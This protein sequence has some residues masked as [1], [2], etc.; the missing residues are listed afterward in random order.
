MSGK[1][2]HGSL[3]VFSPRNP[4]TATAAIVINREI[5]RNPRNISSVLVHDRDVFAAAALE[6]VARFQFG[7]SWIARFNHQEKPIIGGA[8]ES[9]P[10]KNRMMWSRQAVHDEDGEKRS[11]SREEHGELEHDREKRRHRFPVP[12][13][14]VD[15]Q[16]VK[17]PRGT[18]FDEHGSEQPGN[19]AA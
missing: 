18:E 14:A 3:V 5:K 15:N 11:E 13:F 10:V 7:E 19:A 12:R 8:L 9:L 2:S 6:Q 4:S 16:A 17:S 1:I